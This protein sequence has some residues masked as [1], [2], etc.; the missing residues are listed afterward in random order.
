MPDFLLGFTYPF[1][2][3][4]FFLRRPALWKFA[5]A[6]FALNLLVLIVLLVLFFS[7]RAEIVAW[8][9]PER[10]P[11]WL[12]TTASWLLS[13]V[14]VVAGL[15]LS[16]LL[17]NLLASP[18]LDVMTERILHDLGE[19]LPPSR[20]LAAMLL[21]SLIN[22]TLKLFFFGGIQL[23]LLLLWLT[24]LAFLHPPMSAFLA[25]LFL[26]FEYLDYPLDARQVS[27]PA[28]FS[29]LAGHPGATLGFGSVLFLVLLVPLLGY[30]LLPVAVAGAALL[31]HRL[32]S[33]GSTG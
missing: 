33:P 26:G 19:R 2:G 10:L 12:R 7:F 3:L 30:L 15:F 1:R 29:W 6:A 22:Q 27:V 5:A 21:R 17:G 25:I 11:G 4:A 31:A 8:I 18:F 13:A 20:G 23:L 14:A 16:L 32:D 9:T 28:R 24:P